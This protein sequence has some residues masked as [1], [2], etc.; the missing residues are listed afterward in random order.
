MGLAQ[1]R[2]ADS[3]NRQES[4]NAFETKRRGPACQHEAE[5]LTRR[6][7]FNAA[8]A[9]HVLLNRLRTDQA[10]VRVCP[11]GDALRPLAHL[12]AGHR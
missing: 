3:L 8:V 11:S 7:L 1:E 2:G 6:V 5:A 9:N 12:D 4:I 10:G